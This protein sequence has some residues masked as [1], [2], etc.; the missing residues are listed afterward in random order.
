MD[1]LN[2]QSQFDGFYLISKQTS[3]GKVAQVFNKAANLEIIDLC[4]NDANAHESS[5]KKK[6]K[7]IE[8]DWKETD[9]K[10]TELGYLEAARK[11]IDKIDSL[12]AKRKAAEKRKRDISIVVSTIREVNEKIATRSQ[13]LKVEDSLSSIQDL[14]RQK[15]E[16][17]ERFLLLS[18]K[19]G[20]I[21]ELK[22][23]IQDDTEWLEV[24]IPLKSIKQKLGK[25]SELCYNQS[26]IASACDSIRQ[27]KT[28]QQNA[29]QRQD[30][31]ETRLA[32]LRKQ[33]M[34]ESETCPTCGSLRKHWTME[35]EDERN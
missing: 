6:K 12:I 9:E 21:R 1:E 29:R 31:L 7:G 8:A 32:E 18:E 28:S 33:Q 3:P 22:E 25:L 23:K 24:E 16:K 11:Q 15:K 35:V 26:Q 14:I 30:E 5:L 20:A 17:E 4:V 27:L 13:F 10:I 2:I 34:R 19:I